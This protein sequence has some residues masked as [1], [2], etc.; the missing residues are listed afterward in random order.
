MKI[1]YKQKAPDKKKYYLLTLLFIS[2]RAAVKTDQHQNQNRKPVSLCYYEN[3]HYDALIPGFMFEIS[4]LFPLWAHIA[5][6]PFLSADHG[7]ALGKH[8]ILKKKLKWFRR[9]ITVSGRL[10]TTLTMKMPI[11]HKKAKSLVSKG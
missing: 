6:V 9:R 7:W 11:S 8:I 3:S 4:I 5:A 1:P 10:C 2:M